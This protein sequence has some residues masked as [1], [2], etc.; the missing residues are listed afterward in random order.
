MER[1]FLYLH[2]RMAIEFLLISYFFLIIIIF[3]IGGMLTGIPA[4][5][6]CIGKAS[7]MSSRGLALYLYFA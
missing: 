3:S 6:A 4:E 7:R 1:S 2:L 5:V